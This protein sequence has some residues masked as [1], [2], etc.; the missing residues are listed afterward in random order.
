MTPEK[1]VENSI[2]TY[3]KYKGIFCFK[4][5]TGGIY[6]PTKKLFRK[7][8]S[9]HILNGVSD[10]LGIFPNGT[11]FAIE[12]KTDKTPWSRKTYPTADQKLF[13]ENINNNK[14]V[15]FIARSVQ[16]VEA[17]FVKLL[18]THYAISL[19]RPLDN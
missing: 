9:S 16:D 10:I 13:I 14:G 2:L 19:Q 4:I 18:G 11:M 12:V 15:A 1:Q 6:D 5:N 7:A 3:L 17:V 8:K